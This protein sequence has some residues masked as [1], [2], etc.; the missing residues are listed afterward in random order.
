MALRMRPASGGIPG[1]AT[2]DRPLASN[3]PMPAT[4]TLSTFARTSQPACGG[5]KP[6]RLAV[7]VSRLRRYPASAASSVTRDLSP[8]PMVSS[9]M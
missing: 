3:R 8:S 4:P 5:V 7:A 6:A 1:V 9:V 2:M